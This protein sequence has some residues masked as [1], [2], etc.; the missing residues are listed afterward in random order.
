MTAYISPSKLTEDLLI[1][2]DVNLDNSEDS[3]F[4]DESE[5]KLDRYYCRTILK[6]GNYT[7]IHSCCGD[8]DEMKIKDAI[9]SFKDVTLTILNKNFS[10]GDIQYCISDDDLCGQEIT[11]TVYLKSQI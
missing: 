4:S 9:M 5:F 3:A 6:S 7:I 10:V 2:G 8:I 1:K 11:V